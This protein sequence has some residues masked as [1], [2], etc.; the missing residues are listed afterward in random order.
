MFKT[1]PC[2]ASR[3]VCAVAFLVFFNKCLGT[4]FPSSIEPSYLPLS[5]FLLFPLRSSFHPPPSSSYFHLLLHHLHHRPPRSHTRPHRANNSVPVPTPAPAPQAQK[6]FS[7][8]TQTQTRALHP[9]TH[10][11]TRPQRVADRESYSR[12]L[13]PR[14]VP[15][16]PGLCGRRL[17]RARRRVGRRRC[18]A[19]GA[20]RGS[21]F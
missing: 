20:R 6:P 4:Q 10:T 2:F 9:H 1:L 13:P 14:G 12:P 21:G 3:A 11:R 16:W 17:V 8:P 5:L 15:G 19:G 7:I 18:N